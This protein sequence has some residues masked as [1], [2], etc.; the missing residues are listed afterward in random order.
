MWIKL[1]LYYTNWIYNYFLYKIKIKNIFKNNLSKKIFNVL[2]FEK[3]FW[4]NNCPRKSKYLLS[5]LISDI[6]FLLE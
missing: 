1:S 5:P 2:I 4:K 6:S 3:C